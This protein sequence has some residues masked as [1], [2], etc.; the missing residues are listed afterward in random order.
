MLHNTLQPTEFGS[1]QQFS[2]TTVK[3]SRGLQSTLER[4]AGSYHLVLQPFPTPTRPDHP[5]PGPALDGEKEAVSGTQELGLP[6]GSC[7]RSRRWDH[8]VA[9]ALGRWSHARDAA[10]A[11]ETQS[12]ED[13]EIPRPLLSSLQLPPGVLPIGHSWRLSKSTGEGW[14]TDLRAKPSTKPPP[15]PVA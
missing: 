2:S 3:C 6:G 10:T 14:G 8:G 13:K 4:K 12:R 7:S 9:A 1:Q 5:S 15:A 11:Q